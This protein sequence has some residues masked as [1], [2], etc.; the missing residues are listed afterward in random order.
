M[1][2]LARPHSHYLPIRGII[3]PTDVT[4]LEEGR[5][6]EPEPGALTMADV[7]VLRVLEERAMHGYALLGEYERQEVADWA[8]VSKAQVYYA[9]KKLAEMDLIKADGELPDA[10]A[11]SR[12]RTVYRPTATGRE[13]LLTALSDE[14]WARLRTPHPFATW[15]SLA[16]H[17]PRSAARQ[18]RSARRTFLEAELARGHA[19]LAY[20]ATLF[21]DRA[22]AGDAIIRLVIIQMEAEIAWLTTLDADGSPHGDT[23]VDA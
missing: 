10:R 11:A 14:A 13:R 4:P 17:L 20:M 7:V 16:I 22:R 19:S 8:S 5:Q 21:G 23:T 12:N 2:C 3:P 18:V 15:T 6:E 9:L 1:T